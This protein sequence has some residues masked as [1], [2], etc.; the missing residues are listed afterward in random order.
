MAR[1]LQTQQDVINDLEVDKVNATRENDADKVR[2]LN[3]QIAEKGAENALA[4][5]QMTSF[6]SW[7]DSTRDALNAIKPAISESQAST[8]ATKYQHAILI[9]FVHLPNGDE[10]RGALASSYKARVYAAP[11]LPPPAVPS[12]A[13][14]QGKAGSSA[15]SCGYKSSEVGQTSSGSTKQAKEGPQGGHGTSQTAPKGDED[16]ADENTGK[17]DSQSK[18]RRSPEGEHV[19]SSAVQPSLEWSADRKERLQLVTG[20]TLKYDDKAETLWTDDFDARYSS[21][22]YQ[23]ARMTLNAELCKDDCVCP[24]CGATIR[25]DQTCLTSEHWTP[26]C[27]RC[28]KHFCKDK[29]H[30]LPNSTCFYCDLATKIAVKKAS[31]IAPVPYGLPGGGGEDDKHSVERWPE[32]DRPLLIDLRGP[33]PPEQK[34]KFDHLM[35]LY[36]DAQVL[37]SRSA[38]ETA[39]QRYL[40]E[41][42]ANKQPRSLAPPAEAAS[43]EA[44]GPEASDVK[45]P[46]GAASEGQEPPDEQPAEAQSLRIPDPEQ[47]RFFIWIG[48]EPLPASTAEKTKEELQSDPNFTAFWPSGE[49]A[50]LGTIFGTRSARNKSRTPGHLKKHIQKLRCLLQ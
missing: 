23:F 12:Q 38:F 27:M 22:M 40:Q 36:A 16:K 25:K 39:V 41:G 2:S 15:S 11:P 20:F 3:I 29:R 9:A 32:D 19:G 14:S 24:D 47:V 34:A 35:S 10:A 50:P 18:K 4:R 21:T 5:M 30:L 43:A 13:I 28:R 33:V 49:P 37:T 6:T 46:E 8:M 45:A 42:P 17:D 44:A 1:F 7:I 48:S 26:Q 31:G